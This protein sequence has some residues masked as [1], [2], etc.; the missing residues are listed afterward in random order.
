MNS[1]VGAVTGAARDRPSL[2]RIGL[3]YGQC[4]SRSLPLDMPLVEDGDVPPM[5]FPEVPWLSASLVFGPGEPP[6]PLT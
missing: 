4:S 2:L 5:V 6:V 3:F 1:R